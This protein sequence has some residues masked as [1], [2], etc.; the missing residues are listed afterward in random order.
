M[1]KLPESFP[2]R[3]EVRRGGRWGDREEC[4]DLRGFRRLLRPG[5]KGRKKKTDSENDREP[6]QPHG[7]LL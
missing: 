6:D 4:T 3:F 1:A 5:H 2:E 7:H